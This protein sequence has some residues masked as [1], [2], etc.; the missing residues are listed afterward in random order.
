[1]RPFVHIALGVALGC[2]ALTGC[3]KKPETL[4]QKIDRL[5]DKVQDTVDPPKGPAE[6]IGR[7]I[8]RATH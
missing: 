3:K 1:M 6:K 4:G 2:V 5:G 8:D 7:D